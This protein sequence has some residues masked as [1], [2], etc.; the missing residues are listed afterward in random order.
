MQQYSFQHRSRHHL[1]HGLL[2]LPSYRLEGPAV[3]HAEL[4][5]IRGK[6]RHTN[7]YSDAA[8]HLRGSWFPLGQT[9]SRGRICVFPPGTDSD[10]AHLCSD[11]KIRQAPQSV[12]FLLLST[13]DGFIPTHLRT[14]FLAQ[15]I[16]FPLIASVFVQSQ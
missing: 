5:F 13:S 10:L 12:E 14:L 15:G 8:Q 3:C 7:R 4:A 9:S 11:G 1:S 2:S 6:E 16:L